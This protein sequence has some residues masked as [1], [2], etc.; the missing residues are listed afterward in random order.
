MRFILMIL[1]GL[2]VGGAMYYF[3]IQQQ[4]NLQPNLK[5]SQEPAQEKAD[6]YRKQQAEMMLKLEQ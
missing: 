4:H 2:G 1:V 3:V 5:A 6:A